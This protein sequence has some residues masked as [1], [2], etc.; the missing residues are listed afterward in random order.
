MKHQIIATIGLLFVTTYGYTQT[1][2]SYEKAL[3][4]MDDYE[5]LISELKEHRENNLISLDRL[6]E[7][8]KDDN[9]IILDSRSRHLFDY[10]HVSGAINLPFTEFTMLNL[11]IVI[12]D[13]NTRIIIYCNNNFIN[14]HIAFDS[15]VAPINTK[16]KSRSRVKGLIPVGFEDPNKDSIMLALNIPTYINLYGYGYENVYELDELVDI[17]DERLTLKGTGVVR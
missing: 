5:T 6:L 1:G 8:Q 14:D 15:K 10:K 13:T 7:M 12:P 4:S 2:Q 9:T 11:R 3:V 16:R 17:N